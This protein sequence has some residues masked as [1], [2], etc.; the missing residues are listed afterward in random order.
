MFAIAQKEIGSKLFAKRD[1]KHG[2]IKSKCHSGW[3]FSSVIKKIIQNMFHRK[4]LASLVLELKTKFYCW[5][6]SLYFSLDTEL[7]PNSPSY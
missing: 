5:S 1:H 7:K 2:T 6:F 4:Q 3:K